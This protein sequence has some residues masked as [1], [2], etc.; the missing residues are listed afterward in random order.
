MRHDFFS[1]AAFALVT[2][3]CVISAEADEPV[4][5][6][7]TLAHQLSPFYQPPAEF[8]GQLGSYRSPLKFADGSIA[9]TPA[10]WAKRRAEIL[11][12]WHERLGAVAAARR[13]AQGQEAGDG[14]ARR[15]TPSQVQVQA[16]PEGKWPT[17]ICSFRRA[18]DRFPPCSSRSTNR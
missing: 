15:A 10:D 5:R 13:A 8:A 1:A 6:R 7:R 4:D 16:S 17:A 14:R 2:F 18:T 3:A 9:K 11:K 12:T